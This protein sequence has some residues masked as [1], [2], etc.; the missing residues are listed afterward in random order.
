MVHRS[1]AQ[2]TLS[3]RGPA[4]LLAQPSE[5]EIRR[6]IEGKEWRSE[7]AR[8]HTEGLLRLGHIETWLQLEFLCSE[9]GLDASLYGFALARGV[10]VT[11]T[12][13]SRGRRLR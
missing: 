13:R 1:V 5:E 12:P 6:A 7:F 3:F 8:H 10:T 4:D 11:A 2:G 9:P